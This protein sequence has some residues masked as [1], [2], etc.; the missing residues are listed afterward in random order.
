MDWSNSDLVP[1][2]SAK[3]TFILS[4]IWFFLLLFFFWA[5][6]PIYSSAP[7]HWLLFVSSIKNNNKFFLSFLTI[8]LRFNFSSEKVVIT[9]V[10]FF[11]P[12][13][14]NERWVTIMLSLIRKHVK[15]FVSPFWNLKVIV[16]IAEYGNRCTSFIS[17]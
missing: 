2:P 11:V 6:G 14:K 5:S 12:L 3:T 15:S 13:F 8:V 4:V 1:F 7:S 16:P 10:N 9:S 17:V